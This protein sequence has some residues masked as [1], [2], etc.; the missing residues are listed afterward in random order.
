[1]DKLKVLLATL[2]N[3]LRESMKEKSPEELEAFEKR[4]KRAEDLYVKAEEAVK[5][6]H[7]EFEKHFDYLIDA[8]DKHQ[9][10][11]KRKFDALGSSKQ[12]TKE[13]TSIALRLNKQMT[14]NQESAYEQMSSVSD[15]QK[16]VVK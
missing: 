10:L 3:S 13:E 2:I 6:Q 1:M 14:R 16:A 8:R 7:E 5:A 12:G 4:A 11:A 9:V 15:Y